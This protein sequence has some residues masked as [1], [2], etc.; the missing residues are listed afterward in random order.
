MASDWGIIR[1]CFLGK[2]CD[3]I[4]G[5]TISYALDVFLH[6]RVLKS[7]S[8]WLFLPV[9]GLL[10]VGSF[11]QAAP[12]NGELE[13]VTLQ[14]KWRHQFQFAG[15]YAAID[16]GYY[17]E[18][19]LNV[20]LKEASPSMD[21]VRVVLEGKAEYGVG[22]SELLLLRGRG[23]PVV[24]LATIFQHSPLVLL[25]RKSEEISDLQALHDQ[26]IMIEPQSAELFAYFK[27]EGVDPEKL[28]IKQHTF[29]MSDLIEGEVAAMSAYSTDE[30][31]LMRQ[32]DLDF[33]VFT[34]RAGGIDFYG[35]NLFTTESEIRD[36]PDRVRKFRE[37]SLRG[38]AYAMAH[39][40]EIID[41][42]RETY[43]AD[44][45]REH[46]VFEAE[47]MA[48]LLHTNLIEVGHTNPGRWRHM[49]DTYADFGMLPYRYDLG[50]FLYDPNPMPDYRW[51][52]W[53]MGGLLVI[54][55]AGFGWALPLWR[56]NRRLQA[57]KE[58]AEAADRAKSRY[59]AFM[60]HEL[61]SP[62]SGITG[63]IKELNSGWL[64]TNQR[65]LVELL[66]HA[67][68]NQIRLI[69]GVLDYAKME[70]DSLSLEEISLDLAEFVS[71]EGSLFRAVARTKEI[72]LDWDLA[73]NVPTTVL[74]D[75][76]RLRQIVA[77]LLSNAVKFTSKG[78][79]RLGVSVDHEDVADQTVWLQFKVSDTG[80]GMPPDAQSNLFQP[81]QQGSPSVSREY[82]G[83][84]LGLAITK[85][86]V[87]LMK[88]TIS[89]NSE[90]GEGSQFTVVIPVE[91]V[92]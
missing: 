44:K 11:V 61:R 77:N 17:R 9:A 63:V 85:R 79:V 45:S 12:E 2:A 25:V 55:L 16:Q 4:R 50:E 56:L 36:H 18:A 89:V 48:L 82:G 27:N 26:P 84:G 35:D 86:L 78:E 40:E 21:P 76:T 70:A 28:H 19:G 10:L 23:E 66:D 88:G 52:Y 67:A 69:D 43:R 39:P 62:I 54:A 47:Q 92:D 6:I 53:A 3:S 8:R 65:E 71:R 57:A 58:T 1:A 46:L 91:R 59:L 20:E 73:P 42:I 41:H 75:P 34:P 29:E 32:A 60:T 51:V 74:T 68:H 64:S 14:L 83:T 81:Y 15:Y 30:P 7:L 72:E 31:F 5:H 13:T 87:E 33:M 49:A 24:M 37:A 38:W 90:Q 22:T 80:V